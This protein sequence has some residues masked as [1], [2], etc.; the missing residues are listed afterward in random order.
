MTHANRREEEWGFCWRSCSYLENQRSWTWNT[1]KANNTV[2]L[3]PLPF[4]SYIAPR[5]RGYGL[6]AGQFQILERVYKVKYNKTPANTGRMLAD[7]LGID[8][9]TFK[10]MV[11]GNNNVGIEQAIIHIDKLIKV[12]AKFIPQ[13]P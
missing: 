8:H 4:K 2:R 9:K 13:S 10:D 5:L 11:K 1:F 12:S 3:I 7:Y 6:F